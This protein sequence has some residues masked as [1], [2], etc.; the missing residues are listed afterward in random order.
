LV[1]LLQ[2][3]LIT[4]SQSASLGTSPCNVTVNTAATAAITNDANFCYLVFKSGLNSWTAP[5]GVTNIS[6]LLIGGGGA[7]GGGAWAGGGGAGGVV[8][9]ANYPVTPGSSYSTSI[10]AG[11][12]PGGATL[13]IITNQST[14][15]FDTWFYSNSTMVAKGGGAGASYAYGQSAGSLCSGRSGGSGGGS[16]ECSYGSINAGGVSTQTLPDGADLKYGFAGGQTPSG[17]FKS[18][19][20]GGGAGESGGSV[21]AKAS[22]GKGGN[23][24]NTY[25]SFLTAILSSMSDVSGWATATTSGY[26]A[27][28]GA[29][30]NESTK[31]YGGSG[32]GG[33]GGTNASNSTISGS[34]G[35]LNTGSG[36]GGGS[37]NG[38]SGIGGAGG[39]GIIIIRYLV[40]DTTAPTITGP[41]SAT[42]ATSS[43]SIA[44]NATAVYTFTANETVTWSKSGTDSSFFSI[45]S[46]GVLTITARDFE[47]PADSDINNTYVVVVTATNTASNATTQTLTVSITNVNEAPVI[48]NNSSGA[49]YSISQAENISS[50]VTYVATDV[51]ASTTL[52]W[53]IAGTDAGDFTIGSSSGVLAFA[54]S[55][56]YEAPADSDSNNIY[57]VIVTI[58]DGSLTDT[59]TLTLTITNANESSTIGAA[60]ISGA[61]YK[62]INI[63]ITVSLDVAG[64]VRFLVGGKR[65]AGCL[66]KT[67]SGSYPN[68]SATCSWKPT[69]MGRQSVSARITP[70]DNTFSAVTSVASAYWVL[71]RAT[72]R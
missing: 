18:G 62:G 64:K 32:G 4:P 38:T 70:T 50:V 10:G 72:T 35:I 36:G 54:V 40:S 5:V 46:G 30:A 26:I 21:T 8:Y 58:S 67:T 14:S 41:S 45:T 28:G 42:G 22:P 12:S 68:Y 52:S 61:I 15:G 9:D 60:S 23:G 66:A 39:S 6:F 13:S 57:I 47:S 24:I 59:Q 37:Y 20:G 2:S 56:D 65:I 55:P 31:A 43:I 11:G 25:S 27:G 34:A 19:A 69:V 1:L 63:T 49:T 17:D 33:N 44:E 53:S 7:G 16:T 51:D 71:K 3:I 29:G 48:T